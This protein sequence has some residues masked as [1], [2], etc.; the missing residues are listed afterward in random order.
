[1][2]YDVEVVEGLSRAMI[3]RGAAIRDR[4]EH[5]YGLTNITEYGVH[6][7][8]KALR[9]IQKSVKKWSDI[10]GR[11]KVWVRDEDRHRL[12]ES[13]EHDLTGRY[14]TLGSGPPPELLVVAGRSAV[15]QLSV[16]ASP[17]SAT[18]SAPDPLR[19]VT[20]GSRWRFRTRC[21]DDLT[22]RSPGPSGLSWSG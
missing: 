21:A 3:S 17:S 16:S 2:R 20:L 12:D 7:A 11:L 13:V 15:V 6:D 22:S 5:L 14:P 4:L 8:A 19:K 18:V 1:M 9:E 10:H